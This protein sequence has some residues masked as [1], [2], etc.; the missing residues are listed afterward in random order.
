MRLPGV[1]G[2]N[3][4]R[5]GWRVQAQQYSPSLTSIR[6]VRRVGRYWIEMRAYVSRARPTDR[7]HGPNLL[8]YLID[9]WEEQA[10]RALVR[11]LVQVIS[12]WPARWPCPLHREA[13]GPD[14]P[15]PYCEAE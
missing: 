10:R 5:D 9:M 14:G 1:G 12:R 6:L 11:R 7:R 4:T 15:C 2:W 13:W 3:E 8:P